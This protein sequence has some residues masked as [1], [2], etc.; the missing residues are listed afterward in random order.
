MHPVAFRLH[1]PALIRH[2][3]RLRHR[4]RRH[5]FLRFGPWRLRRE[6]QH[7]QETI[8]LRI[9]MGETQPETRESGCKEHRICFPHDENLDHA[10]DSFH[11]KCFITGC[12]F[13]YAQGS[14]SDSDIVDHVKNEHTNW[15]SNSSF[16]SGWSETCLKQTSF[17]LM[18]RACSLEE[19]ENSMML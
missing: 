7:L 9:S 10:R 15:E 1:Y 6:M 18:F 13:M 19:Y 8:P 5:Q 17:Y 14:W 16:D 12:D 4:R 3:G 11:T 2:H